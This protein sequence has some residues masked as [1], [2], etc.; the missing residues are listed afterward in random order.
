MQFG[1]QGELQAW[2]QDMQH[3]E[4]K[5]AVVVMQEKG[6]LGMQC[7]SQ[8]CELATHTLASFPRKDGSGQIC[9]VV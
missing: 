7:G 2:M 4:F 5:V 1:L 3:T 6:A 9:C 8:Q